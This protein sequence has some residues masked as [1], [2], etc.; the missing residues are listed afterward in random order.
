LESQQTLR[1]NIATNVIAEEQAKEE[2]N[3][4]Q[5]ANTAMCPSQ[6]AYSSALNIM[7]AT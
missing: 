4:K 1:R 6:N 3:I 2:T 7:E 5:A